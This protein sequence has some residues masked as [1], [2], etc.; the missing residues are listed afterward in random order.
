MRRTGSGPGDRSG[1]IYLECFGLAV[2]MLLVL[3]LAFAYRTSEHPGNL[4]ADSWYEKDWR[5]WFQAQQLYRRS[6][7]ELSRAEFD[8]VRRWCD[9]L[10]LIAKHETDGIQSLTEDECQFVVDALDDL[11]PNLSQRSGYLPIYQACRRRLQGEGRSL[12]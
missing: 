6:P 10:T 8:N 7:E 9:C 1:N 2:A 3:Q 12:A 11:C 4:L 5:M